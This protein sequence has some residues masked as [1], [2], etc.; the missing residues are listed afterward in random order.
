MGK[1]ISIAVS[2]VLGAGLA[3]GAS[4]GILTSATKAPSHNPANSQ[5]VDYG[6]R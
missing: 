6:N 3:V 4:I 2:A 5:V 1:I